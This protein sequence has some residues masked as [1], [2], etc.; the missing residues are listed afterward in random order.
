[1]THQRHPLLAAYKGQLSISEIALGIRL[2]LQNARDLVQDA[3]CLMKKSRYA[4]ALGC[5][6]TADQEI[7]KIGILTA[8][9]RI[10]PSAQHQWADKWKRFRHHEAKAAHS[11]VAG[12]SNDWRANPQL[13][14]VEAVRFYAEGA[15]LAERIRQACYYVDFLSSPRGWLSPAQISDAEVTM[16]LKYTNDALLRIEHLFH[17]GLYSEETLEIQRQ[18]LGPITKGL[19]PEENV[20]FKDLL[21]LTPD[22]NPEV[23]QAMRRFWR[24]ILANR[25]ITLPNESEAMQMP[26]NEFLSLVVSYLEAPQ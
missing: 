12:L 23:D 2:C 6:L 9:A 21:S 5:L 17:L 7:G 18:E 10:H 20:R 13:L 26:W 4:R 3:E 15:P 8:M 11:H 19:P 16:R 1:M 25:G 22:A 24:R 14:L